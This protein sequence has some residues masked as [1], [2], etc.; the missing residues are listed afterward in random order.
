VNDRHQRGHIT[1]PE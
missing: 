1:N